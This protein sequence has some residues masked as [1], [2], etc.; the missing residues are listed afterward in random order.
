MTAS[1]H[2]VVIGAGTLGMCSAHALAEQGARVTVID[3]QS[4]ASGSS[5]RSVGVVG[6]QL[7]DPFEI[8]LRMQSVQRVRRWQERLGL[9]FSPIGYLRL[10]RT[11][12]QMELFAR[13][14]EIQRDAGFRSRVYQANELQQL[15]PHLSSDGLEGGIF[16][17]DDGFLDPHEM[18][19]LLAQQ[20]KKLG[21]EVFQF[22][23]LLGAARTSG[24]Y[25]LDT[26]KGPI[27][28]DFVVN[29]A[30]AWAPRVAEMLGQT[31][32]I[33][34][35]RH[36]ALTIHLDAP[37]PY[38]MPMVM[39]LVNGQGTGLN[40]R[41]EKAS[42]LIAEI[43]KVSSPSPEDPDNYN[44]Q[45]EEG[46]KVMLAQMLIER[47]PDLPGARLGRGWAGL[48]PVTAD[49]RPY[50]GPVDQS[51]PGLITAAGAGG[52]GIQLAPVIG[53][54]VADWVLKGSPASIPGTESLAPTPERNV[55]GTH[56]AAA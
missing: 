48:Y 26:S 50:V 45:C 12:E 4:I 43:H 24:G 41:H 16:G 30:G 9:G 25:R 32:H 34:P 6:T 56:T 54:I 21:S 39:D 1:P 47:L 33:H 17:P 14:V 53:L 13:S 38:T 35:E 7:T 18:C 15:V 49:H 31:L 40:F 51:E 19:T 22:R 46:S 20:V 3:A 29:A 37:L 44:D 8:Q 11:S 42:E 27:G 23:K 10:A 36:E 28:C 2:V 52:Y 5:G 55:P